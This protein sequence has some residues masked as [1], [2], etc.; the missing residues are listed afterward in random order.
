MIRC[1]LNSQ[2]SPKLILKSI[3]SESMQAWPPLQKLLP[4]ICCVSTDNEYSDVWCSRRTLHGNQDSAAPYM[5][6]RTAL[7]LTWQSGQRCTL[8]GNQ[9]STLHGNQDSAAPYMAIRTAL[10]LTWQSG[11]HL[12]W[13]SG[14]R[15]TLHGNQDSAAPYM[16]IRT[17]PY[18]AIRTALHLTWQS[19]QRC[20]LHGN[21]DSAAPLLHRR[22]IEH[23]PQP[24]TAINKKRYRT[25][26]AFQKHTW[27]LKSERS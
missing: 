14:Q 23:W 20:T 6:I 24:T 25:M 21:Q 15:C 16:A 27:A 12:T 11:Q 19:G 13:Q 17:A 18:M 4:I 9:D 26:G 5:A 2:K 10:H 22:L 3:K 8:H 7:H 1:L